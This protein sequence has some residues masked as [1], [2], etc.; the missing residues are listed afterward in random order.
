MEGRGWV[1]CD[2]GGEYD[3][4]PGTCISIDSST[5]CR[6]ARDYASRQLFNFRF[7]DFVASYDVFS[8][9]CNEYGEFH[10]VKKLFI[11]TAF[12]LYYFAAYSR[13]LTNCDD[14]VR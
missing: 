7:D 2:G 13:Q 3:T 14:D 11:S 6:R 8:P 10:E 4:L 5:T 12:K 9:V 1:R